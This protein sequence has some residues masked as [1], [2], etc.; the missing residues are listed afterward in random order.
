VSS[1]ASYL[2][3]PGCEPQAQNGASDY[4]LKSSKL[5]AQIKLSSYQLT[6]SDFYSNIKLTHDI[7]FTRPNDKS[8]HK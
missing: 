1:V 5:R 6:I 2:P 4:E 7:Q 8:L 3:L